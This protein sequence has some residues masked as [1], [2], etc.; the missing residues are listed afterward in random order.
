[1]RIN[2]LEV[3]RVTP[4]NKEMALKR[5]T[6]AEKASSPKKPRARKSAVSLFDYK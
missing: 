2:F 3:Y 1:M 6:D 4:A 5:A